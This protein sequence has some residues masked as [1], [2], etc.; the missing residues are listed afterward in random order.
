MSNSILSPTNPLAPG[1]IS[2]ETAKAIEDWEFPEEIR[3]GDRVVFA[4]GVREMTNPAAN[5]Y[6][7]IAVRVDNR[8]VDIG[9]FAGGYFQRETCRHFQDPELVSRPWLVDEPHT[10]VF[11]LAD[12]ELEQR[13]LAARLDALEGVPIADAV[14]P[15][16]PVEEPV[17]NP[18]RRGPGRPPKK[19]PE[20]TTDAS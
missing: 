1:E 3:V 20:E 10:G 15:E 13:A 17:E 6:P 7:G 9:C 8:T 5:T 19:K 4:Q 14:F 16:K 12:A 18:K 2:P 11:R